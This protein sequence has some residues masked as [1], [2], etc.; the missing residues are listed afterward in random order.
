MST[1]S[2]KT[3]LDLLRAEPRTVFYILGAIGLILLPLLIASVAFRPAHGF[4]IPP[5]DVQLISHARTTNLHPLLVN[6]RLPTV[7]E[8]VLN[9][10]S[11]NDFPSLAT[12]QYT[13]RFEDKV[14]T[15]K[16]TTVFLSAAP[17]GTRV[18]FN[19]ISLGVLQYQNMA[20]P[21]LEDYMVMAEIPAHYFH[22]GI[23]TLGV[24]S[25]PSGRFSNTGAIYLG[26][27][28]PLNITLERLN[29]RNSL[30]PIFLVII[31][32]LILTA[33]LLNLI[34]S[35]MR[36]QDVW[37][38]LIGGITLTWHLF[39]IRDVFLLPGSQTALLVCAVMTC[40]FCMFCL[41]RTQAAQQVQI[42]IFGVFVIAA[43]IMV[44]AMRA[45]MLDLMLPWV[46]TAVLLPILIYSLWFLLRFFHETQNHWEVIL[47]FTAGL[48]LIPSLLYGVPALTPARLSPSAP[49]LTSH[50]LVL[51]PVGICLI[52]ATRLTKILQNYQSE[53][54]RLRLQIAETGRRLT[55][56]EMAL[57]SEMRKRVQLEERQ[58]LSRDMHDGIGGQLL[59][60]LMRVRS[61]RIGM[62]QVEGEIE[63]GIHDLRLIIDTMDQTS[64]DLIKVMATFR[65]R[66]SDQ[67]ED[68]GIQL[69]WNQ[70]ENI[71]FKSSGTRMTLNIYRFSQEAVSNTIRHANAK[72][73]QIS[74]D[75]KTSDA[76][77]IIMIQDDGDGMQISGQQASAGKGL[78]NMQTRASALGG[79]MTIGVG[80]D[81][82]GVAITLTIPPV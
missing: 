21:G 36:M 16:P 76:P 7:D 19:G 12:R 53:K 66:T 79:E 20:S 39:L 72:H 5:R 14:Y 51:L 24:V 42:V 41:S 13:Y 28:L 67:L 17:I 57:Q 82:Q 74:L 43:A 26:P 61:G 78:K 22:P 37:M 64:D 59:S 73:L 58:Q 63:N 65:S 70:S 11:Q 8:E 2:L 75:Q 6:M 29:T 38:L 50:L 52:S 4:K 62:K 3:V 45:D 47:L 25:S 1:K 34:L 48:S 27:K 10:K 23:N 54:S 55:E 60:L 68:S 40:L 81:G 9:L 33:S 44:W 49:W 80:I 69:E 35:K 77:L 30:L 31:G 32:V 71:Y 15:E 46:I 18:Y 56:K